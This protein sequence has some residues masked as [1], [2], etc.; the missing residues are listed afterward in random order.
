MFLEFYELVL[1]FFPDTAQRQFRE[2]IEHKYRNTNMVRPEVPL[3]NKKL[4]GP[5]FALTWSGVR[6]H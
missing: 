5:W 6:T 3:E 2:C 1:P 4:S